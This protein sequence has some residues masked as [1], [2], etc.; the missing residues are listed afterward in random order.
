MNSEYIFPLHN[1]FLLKPLNDAL[2]FKMNTK[3]QEIRKK[4]KL[5]AGDKIRFYVEFRQK[6]AP[7]LKME[8]IKNVR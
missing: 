3:L 2:E 5:N 6:K 7:K 4:L 8:I 1:R